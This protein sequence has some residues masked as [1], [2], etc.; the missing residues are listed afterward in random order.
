MVQNEQLDITVVVV[1][2]VKDNTA[3]YREI[4]RRARGKERKIKI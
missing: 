2:I 3:R 1:V 4:Q